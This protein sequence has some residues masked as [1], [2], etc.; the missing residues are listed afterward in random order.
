[1][2]SYI[3]FAVV[4]LLSC[5]QLFA[6]PLAAD[7]S[8]CSWHFQA[9]NWS[10]LPFSSPVDHVL[11]EL[12]PRTC[13]SWVALHGMAHGFIELCKPLSQDKAVMYKIDN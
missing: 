9:R 3:H 7:F 1:M 10:G 6:I 11:S 4:Q 5:D 13:L 12:F 8:Y 2:W